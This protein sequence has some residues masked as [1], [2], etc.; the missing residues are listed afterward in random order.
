MVLPTDFTPFRNRGCLGCRL[1]LAI[2]VLATM[3][4]W[5]AF[6]G[7]VASA[8]PGDDW[9][10]STAV[11]ETFDSFPATAISS[12]D[13][14]Y[15]FFAASAGDAEIVD[16]SSRGFGRSLKINGA[17]G[18]VSARSITLHFSFPLEEESPC[19]F[20]AMLGGR[21]QRMPIGWSLSPWRERM[22]M[23]PFPF[24][25]RPTAEFPRVPRP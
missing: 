1:W 6:T 25:R 20:R 12:L 5:L 17:S 22:G 18:S 10:N 23:E 19:A 9:I 3:Y 15:G 24:Q 7:T 8:A 4:C 2:A 11:G 16:M 13:G 21:L 14:H